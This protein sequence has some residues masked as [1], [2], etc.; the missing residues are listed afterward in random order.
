M[1]IIM[2]NKEDLFKVFG[3]CYSKL[4]IYILGVMWQN[5]LYYYMDIFYQIYSLI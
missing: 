3:K 5:W 2:V 1:L 4:I